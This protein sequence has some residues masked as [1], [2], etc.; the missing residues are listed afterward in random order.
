MCGGIRANIRRKKKK[1][2]LESHQ[3]YLEQV[4]SQC[5][6]SATALAISKGVSSLPGEERRE[7]VRVGGLGY[8]LHGC[9]CN[10][11]VRLR[12]ELIVVHFY[13]GSRFI[14]NISLAAS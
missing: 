12:I 14:E 10:L 7:W 3:E 4:V 8:L 1:K 13:D 2:N 11:D 5:R 6:R 9:K